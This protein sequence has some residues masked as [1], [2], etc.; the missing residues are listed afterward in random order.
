MIGKFS[1]FLAKV[2]SSST[3][4]DT[5]TLVRGYFGSAEPRA[6]LGALEDDEAQCA[7]VADLITRLEVA[8]QDHAVL[9]DL[10]WVEDLVLFCLLMTDT[11]RQILIGVLLAYARLASQ[12]NRPADALCVLRIASDRLR[13][14]N[15]RE[16]RNGLACANM[17][18]HSLHMLGRNRLALRVLGWT[19]R[20]RE[21]HE[22]NSKGLA[23]TYQNLGT[24]Y[25]LLE[26][27]A[28]A[29]AALQRALD[30]K[31]AID[32]GPMSISKTL[33][34]MAS[35][36]VDEG[37][38][39]AAIVRLE[40][41]LRLRIQALTPR[42]HEI[43]ATRLRLAEALLLARRRDEARAQLQI[44]GEL[45]DAQPVA[46]LPDQIKE[47][48]R[49]TAFAVSADNFPMD[50]DPVWQ[51]LATLIF[52]APL[53][54]ETQ[55]AVDRFRAHQMLLSR[56]FDEAEAILRGIR[57]DKLGDQTVA[58]IQGN[59]AVVLAMKGAFAEAS[60]VAQNVLDT[61]VPS[62][63]WMKRTLQEALLARARARDGLSDWV[64]LRR[65]LCVN[66]GFH[67]EE[68]LMRASSA[69]FVFGER[70]FGN[71]SNT[72]FW[73]LVTLTFEQ[74]A[75]DR[76]AIAELADALDKSYAIETRSRACIRRSSDDPG[77]SLESIL[78]G[79]RQALAEG[80]SAGDILLTYLQ[81]AERG[82]RTELARDPMILSVDLV[83]AEQSRL[84]IVYYKPI[85]FGA[86]LD[87]SY[88]WHSTGE[89]MRYCAVLTTP[90]T[91]RI[92]D[93]GSMDGV[94]AAI[95]AD[96]RAIRSEWP[97]AETTEVSALLAGLL[98]NAELGTTCDLCPDADFWFYPLHGLNIRGR[99]AMRQTTFRT[100]V[101]LLM[102]DAVPQ[103]AATDLDVLIVGNVDHDAGG[104]ER[105]LR[106]DRPFPSLAATHAEVASVR[107]HFPNSIVL[108]GEEAT[109]AA[110][111]ERLQQRPRMFHFAGHAY[112]P[113]AGVDGPD[114]DE[115]GEWVRCG[116]ALA[117]CN[118][119][120]AGKPTASAV[121]T[122]I[123]L[124][125][126]ISCLSLDGVDLVVIA[127][128]GSALGA[129]LAREP[130]SGLARA[131]QVAGVANVIASLWPVPDA[132]T[133][134]LFDQFYALLR[135]GVRS[136]QALCAAQRIL[137]ENGRPL[138]H[139]GAFV[140]Y[141]SGFRYP[142]SE[143]GTTADH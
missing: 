64:G 107:R 78:L 67:L 24:V 125:L 55:D 99:R 136:D 108:K 101:P 40:R 85:R 119:W 83:P 84:R 93:L 60:D 111:I 81:A 27:R 104:A 46:Y 115:R 88:Q 91:A 29:I 73:R 23:F 9:S 20:M 10:L 103:R 34:V 32:I 3:Q 47:F 12:Q 137:E 114:G 42:H 87:G 37:H 50:E 45:L 96:L 19:A 18:G 75:D 48:R 66:L 8:S 21:Q 69:S 90:T 97:S 44:C 22:P 77:I 49:A 79:N 5:I 62:T 118:A 92:F 54:P 130:M 105:L 16:S 65:D 51:A 71:Q 102:G 120:L 139:W 2:D 134:L 52:N 28:D 25:A 112:W 76:E 26:R 141:G 56:R 41:A 128:C 13:R 7:I 123:L 14:V 70:P 126:D 6:T 17:I 106:F 61:Y 117:G 39:T 133:A 74:F 80:A 31:E 142:L 35:I 116:L 129:V 140:H 59:L 127:G 124:G 98:E 121:S 95:S 132:D 38:T 89:A 100:I 86:V 30:I 110:T 36:Q 131:F 82:S 72:V 43:L 135:G 57:T 68:A 1:E 63:H 15:Q 11:P 109:L 94:Q 138:R 122:G 4:E 143:P 33:M 58:N 113:G 53:D